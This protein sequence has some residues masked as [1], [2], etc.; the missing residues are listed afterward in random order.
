MDSK[1]QGTGVAL[2]TPMMRDGSVDYGALA[3]LTDHTISGGVDYLV[4]QGT[5]GESPTT[6]W[7]EK[8]QILRF[9]I[10]Q[11]GGKLPIV[12]GLGGNNTAELLE[13]S[14]QLKQYELDAILSVN[15]YYSRPSQTGIIKHFNLLA[16]RFPHPVILYNVPARTGSNIT[17]STTVS[18]ADHQNIIAIKEASGDFSQCQQILDQKPKDFILI[19]GDDQMTKELINVGASGVISVIANLFPQNF[20]AMVNAAL[21]NDMGSALKLDNELQKA[22]HLLSEEGNPTS[23]KTGLSLLDLCQ[24]TVRL[25]LVPGSAKLKAAWQNFLADQKA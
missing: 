25:P 24:D 1:F 15:P 2:A 3:K 17:A 16:D 19:S 21:E 8:L 20:T 12:F 11:A 22:Y 23:L 18:L 10:D 7:E 13:Q 5:T 6:T 9:V 4:V 14:D